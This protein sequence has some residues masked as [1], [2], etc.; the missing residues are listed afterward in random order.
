MPVRM[1]LTRL[2]TKKRPFYRIIVVDSEK[3]RDGKYLE[4]VG[5]YDPLVDPALI[6]VDVEKAQSWINKGV[7]PSNTVKTLLEKA[8]MTVSMSG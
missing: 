6:K 8:G 1:R 5:Y 2:G 4:Q 7:I 3:K